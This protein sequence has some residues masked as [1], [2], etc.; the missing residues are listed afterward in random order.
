MN[1]VLLTLTVLILSLANL[2]G[3][4]PDG[5]LRIEML[6][7]FNLVVDHN[8]QTPSGASPRAVYLGVRFCNDG[9]NELTDV[10][11]YIGNQTAGTP[12]VYPVTSVSSGPYTGSFSFTHE[13][14]V[15]DATR[16]IGTLA[17]GEC[18]TQYWL[19]SYPLLDANGNRVTGS[20]PDQTDDLHLSYDVWAS[21]N[22]AGTS[23]NA[24]TS[25]TVQLRAMISASANKIWP[26]TTSK[27]PD[28]FLAAFPDKQLGWRQTTATP[29]PGASVV[30][31]GIWFDLGNIRKGFDNNGDFVPDF[32][33]MLQP[34]GNPALYDASCFRLVKVSGMIAVKLHGNQTMSFEFEDQMHFSGI[35]EDNTGAVGMVF[36]EFAV[37]NGPCAS[38]LT[39]YQE[40]ASGSNNEK[41][42]GDYGVPGG[43][44]VSAAPVVSLVK[45]A[46]PT[47]GRG[48][49]I[50]L[51]YTLTNS[52]AEPIGLTAYQT[53]LV[54]QNKIPASTTYVSGSAAAENILPAGTQVAILFSTDNG[55]SWTETEPSPASSVTDIQW[56]LDQ[57]LNPGQTTS[58]TYDILI[59][60]GYGSPV[61]EARGGASLGNSEPFVQY[62]SQTVIDG[63]FSVSGKVF[64]DNG[65]GGGTIGD[66]VQNGSETGIPN[67]GVKLY[68]DSNENGVY[69]DG[70]ILT[71]EKN[72]NASGNYDFTNLSNGK[73]VVKIYKNDPGLPAQWT[74][75]TPLFYSI[76]DLANITETPVFGYA[77]LLTVENSLDGQSPVFESDIVAYEL[78]L[79]NKSHPSV[80]SACNEE[81][82]AWASVVDGETNYNVSPQN[83]LGAPDFN[84][85]HFTGN[86]SK[87]AV[88]KGFNF[89]DT[90][91]EIQ[92]VE[93]LIQFYID[94]DI[95]NDKLYASIELENGQT[96]TVPNP[97]WTKNSSPS[98]NDYEGVSD[99]GMITVDIT[100][101]QDWDWSIFDADWTVKLIS[102]VKG[103]NDGAILWLDAIGVKI[104]KECPSG[105]GETGEAEPGDQY[106][107]IDELP[108][109]YNFDPG[110]LKFISATVSPDSISSG[111]LFW[112]NAGP[113]YPA[114][115]E[116]IGLNFRALAPD[117]SAC[118]VSAPECTSVPNPYSQCS[119]PTSGYYQDKTINGNVTW[120]SIFNENANNVT[121]MIRVK[122]HGSITVPSG[123]LKIGATLLVVDGVDLIVENGDL[124]M[125]AWACAIFVNSTV[126]VK[127]SLT[128]TTNGF[129]CMTDCTVEIGDELAN[130]I[131]NGT[132]SSTLGHFTNN[133]GTRYLENVCLNVTGDYI[134]N[135]G[136]NGEDVFINVCGHI[137]DRG[138][139][140]A[141]TGVL[142]GLD[143]GSFKVSK[144]ARMYN[145]EFIVANDVQILSG[146]TLQACNI[147]FRT[148]N[149]NFQNSGIFKGCEN[150]IWVSDGRSISNSSSWTANVETRRGTS[151]LGSQYLPVNSSVAQISP[152][153]NDCACSVVGS[154]GNYI[155]T[156]LVV[157]GAKNVSNSPVNEANDIEQI[158][159]LP[160]GS[161]Y[162][163]IF[164]DVDKDGWKGTYGF[165]SGTDYFLEGVE[166]KIY[167]CTNDWGDL[168]YPAPKSNKSCTHSQNGGQWNLIQTDTTGQDGFYS[169]NGLRNGYYYVQVTNA[170][171][172]GELD[173]TADP[174]IT[175][176]DC[177][178]SGDDRWKNPSSN[179]SNMGIIGSVNDHTHINFG[180]EL[181]EAVSGI[182]WEDLDGDGIQEPGEDP[183]QGV[184]VKLIHSGCSNCPSTTTNAGGE[185]Q[186][187]G[188]TPGVNYTLQVLTGSVPGGGTWTVTSESDGTADN[189]IS[190][191]LVSGEQRRRNNFG[192]QPSGNSD[193]GGV[194]YYDWHGNAFRNECDEGIAG[195]TLKLYQDENGDGVL[196]PEDGLIQ[197]RVTNLI[198]QYQFPSKGPGNYI[199]KINE[200]T[201]PI[202]PAQTKDYNEN[203]ICTVCD[204][205]A[206]ILGI[207][208]SNDIADIDFG[209]K[210]TGTGIVR[211]VLFFDSN[212]NGLR[213]NNEQGIGEIEVRLEADLNNNGDFRLIRTIV[214][215]SDGAFRFT[216]LP[217]GPYR[218][219]AN[220]LDENLPADQYGAAEILTTA[221]S[222]LTQVTDASMVSVNGTDCGA[223][224]VETVAFG[225]SNAGSLESFVFFDANANGTMDW[226]ENGIPNIT[227]YLCDD[228]DGTCGAT[229]ALDTVVT[230]ATGLYLFPGLAASDYVVAVDLN[231][232]PSGMVLTADPTAD[233]IPCY[234]PLDMAD[235][236]YNLLNLEC[237]NAYKALRINLG[238]QSRNSNFGYQPGG[239]IGC[240][241]WRDINVNGLKEDNEP[242]LPNIRMRVT[243]EDPA[244]INGIDYPPGTYTDTTYTDFDGN[245][246]FENL[247]DGEWRVEVDN[248]ADMAATY[249]PDGVPDNVTIVTIAGGDVT[250]TGNTWCP[251]GEDCA[252]KVTF[253]LRPNYPNSISGTVCLDSDQDGKCSTG[254]EAFPNGVTIYLADEFGNFW[255]ETRIDD[256]GHYSFEYLPASTF[257]VSI[258][259]E[260]TPLQLAS[261]TTSLGDTPAFLISETNSN[262]FQKVNVTAAL[263]GMDFGFAFTD[264][265]DLGDLPLP[266]QST[267]DG[268]YAGPAHLLPD[269]PNLYL[270][271]M[272]DAETSP[273]LNA[274]ASGDDDNGNDDDGITFSDPGGWTAGP[275]STG[276]GGSLTA[277]VT[278]AGWL[279]AWLDFNRDGDFTDAG[280]MAISQ[281]VTTGLYDIDFDIPAG[282]VLSGGQDIYVRVRLFSS[283]PFAPQ[284]AYDGIADNGEVEDYLVSVCHNL[285]F[286][287]TITGAET[288]C[289]NC[290]PSMITVV[291][292]PSGGGG[293]IFY[294]WQQS[295]NGGVTWEDIAGATVDT[296]TPGSLSQT[297]LFRRG[298]KRSRCGNY[299]YS[300]AVAKTVVTNFTD[301][302]IIVG[303][304]D[305][306]GIY[307]PDIIVSVISPSGGVGN[308]LLLYQWQQSM[309]DGATWLDI[310]NAND[311][312]FNPGIISQTTKYR[313]SSQKAPCMTF[314]YSNVITKM[315]AVNFVSG[316]TIAGDETFCGSYDPG[317]IASVSDA[318]GGADGY[319]MYQWEYSTN[320]GV[321]WTTISG[322]TGL[323]YNPGTISQTTNY[324]RKARR[325]PCSVWVNSN[326]V[327]K[328]VRQYPVAVITT[329]PSSLSGYLCEL[330]DYEFDAADAGAGAT[331]GWDFG[332]YANPASKS[333]KGSHFVEFDVP[334]DEA[335]STT[336]VTLTI[337]KNG[338][339]ATDS[340][341][342]NLRPEIQITGIILDDP[343][344]CKTKNGSIT[345]NATS[346]AGTSIEYTVDG[347]LNWDSDNSITQLGAGVYEVMVRYTGSDCPET[348]GIVALSDPPPAAD[349][350]ISTT[351]TCT[352][353][354]VTVE[355]VATNG[356]PTFSW[357]FGNNASPATASGAGPHNVTFANGGAASIAV[358]MEDGDCIG[359]RDTTIAIVQ[360]Y[361]SG[362]AILGGETLC[363]TFDPSEI[364]AS[365]NPSGGTGGTTVYQWEKRNSNGSGGWTAWTEIAGANTPGYDPPI[366]SVS[367]QYRRKVRRAPCSD[368][369]YSNEVAAVL[370]KKP[371]LADD[372]YAT[373][374]PGFPY[375]G[376]VSDNDLNLVSPSFN[377]LTFPVNGSLDFDA[378]GEFIYDP[379]ATFCGSESFTYVVCN[380]GSTCCDTA[381]VV[382][383]M[384]DNTAPSIVN[385]PADITISCDDQIPLAE[386]VQVVENCQMISLGLN[387]FITKGP[388]M[389]CAPY[390]YQWVRIWNSVD[391]C[392]NT[393]S[394]QQVIHVQDN[395]SPDIYR[396]YTLPNGKR[397][398]AGVMENVSKY[399]KTVSLPV[400]FATQPVVFTQVTSRDEASAVVVRLRN[401]STTQFQI[402]LQ[403]EEGNDGNHLVEK[404]AWVAMEKGAQS[405]SLPFEVNT[406]L[407]GSNPANKALG[408]TY[409]S[410]PDF[411]ASMQ[412]NNDSD[413][414]NVRIANLTQNS[415]DIWVSEENSYDSE[416]T[417]N[418]ET[419]GYLAIYS[420]GDIK[421]NSGEVIGEVGRVNLTH[422]IQVVSLNNEYH[423][424][425]VITG[426]V[427]NNET[428][429]VTARVMNV[430]STS[431]ELKLDE[432]DYLDGT[433][434]TENV[435]YMVIE[436]SLPLDRSVDCDNIPAALKIGTE[437]VA[438]DN[439]DAHIDFSMTES[440]VD[441]N[442]QSDTIFTRTWHTF[443]DCGNVTELVQTYR[444]IDTIPP[445]FTVPADVT[446]V[447]SDSKDNLAKTGDVTDESDNCALGVNAVYTDNLSN[448]TGCTG[449]ILRTWTAQDDCGNAT[450]KI[451]TISIAPE[452]DTD[453]DGVVDYF[454]LDD[455]NDG[456]PDEIETENDFDLDGIP[457]SKDLDSDND[458]IPDLIEAGGIDAN[459]DGVIDFVGTLGWDHDGDGLA[460]GFDGNDI[461]KS[462]AA[463]NTFNPNSPTN[464]RDGDG[465]PNFLDRDSDNDGIPDLIE[466]GGL[467][468]NGD[469]IVDYPVL[470]DP[471]TMIDADG[472]GFD[473]RYDPDDDNVPGAE[474][475]HDPLIVFNGSKYAGGL[476]TDKPDTDSDLVPDFLDSDSDNDGISDLIEAGG[477][478][479]DGD[480]KLELNASFIDLNNDGF[481]DI[482]VTYPLIKTDG[483]GFIINGRPE[484]TNSDGTAFIGGDADFDGKPN[485]RDTDSDNDGI[486]DTYE[487]GIASRDVNADGVIDNFIDL[488]LNGFDDTAQASANI[489]TESDGFT[490]DGRPEDSSDADGTAYLGA[491][492]DGAFAST[493]GNPDIDD[494]GDGILNFLDTDSDNDFLS[495]KIEDANGN[496]IFDLGETGLFNPDTDGDDII[497]GVED[498]NHNGKLDTGETDPLNPD[499]D[500]DQLLD[501]EEDLN[502]D[503][504]AGPGESDPIDPCDPF[505]SLACR[506]VVLNV[507]VKLLGPL[508]GNDSTNYM[509]DE[510]RYKFV[511]PTLEPYTSM[512]NLQ[513]VGENGSAGNP[514][515]Q[516]GQSNNGKE[517]IQPGLLY[518]TGLDAPVDWV[519]IELRAASKP[520]SIV[521]SRAAVLQADGD[522][523]DVDG[524]SYVKF[525]EFPSGE[526]F[527]AIRHRN[528]LGVMTDQPY[529]LSPSPTSIDF[530]D[531]GLE[532][533]G[534]ENA[535]RFVNGEMTLW[536]GDLN[537]DGKVVYQ[538]PGNDVLVLFQQVLVNDFNNSELA[539][540]VLEGYRTSDLNLDG[541]SIFQGPNNDK[542][543]LLINT[544]FSSPDNLALWANFVLFEKLP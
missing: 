17:P 92:K 209:Y 196:Q 10:F 513:H 365:S 77:P 70:D 411:F 114:Q 176:G 161:V 193:L 382:I 80:T 4:N 36:Y 389:M 536:P 98:L 8:I 537:N 482:Y 14:G 337:T 210:V 475:P 198:G 251:S 94:E 347:G 529:L 140:D 297:T 200:N 49:Q 517:K 280:E 183:L 270:G 474:D 233:G 147:D 300:N 388:D 30:L 372:N 93:L 468:T 62:L 334:D 240:M 332:A 306:C 544:T 314:V 45:I 349:I 459:G 85:A 50:E 443:D 387:E 279:I 61:L 54:F 496:G 442:C 53:P 403:E 234:T 260:Q 313:R 181:D 287:G 352:G 12:G 189:A 455:D 1:K 266:Y 175:N 530:S 112:E 33:F 450:T 499:T 74:N 483:D 342:L 304:Q 319:Q 23:R 272:V 267:V 488:D 424:P 433:H 397:M 472:D 323:T 386:A 63:N 524:I 339:F 519:L 173:Q 137:G 358:T 276:N 541:S 38:Q 453:H 514:P 402:R 135:S 432:F 120:S 76:E 207:N 180:Y 146:G 11:A 217:D 508:V 283:R 216:G 110:K 244:N 329:S 211:G 345:I 412:T 487:T 512:P 457:N 378:D 194:V 494:D 429:P 458:G 153:F 64:Q 273:D 26:N 155:T 150:T 84:M 231:T 25:K 335:S 232:L 259:K 490:I 507:R 518:V 169:F 320:G 219:S 395:T 384:T 303:D 111:A 441:F 338:C 252:M 178:N 410:Q 75:T 477:V 201:L 51:G 223:C 430:T 282:T 117:P 141:S 336:T 82:Y 31:E 416:T 148:L 291:N 214:S 368:W 359:V 473:D 294:Q 256:F 5:D 380:D 469:G 409:P 222:F 437:I 122:G 261:M 22:D 171:I 191:N 88:V 346:P 3:A 277:E 139:S 90:S 152:F 124:V 527:V 37:L 115:T 528:H 281:A 290:H 374:C 67:I 237:D 121:K 367:T 515:G 204:A 99:Q 305:N 376:N 186:F 390:H 138:A 301:P 253:G 134:L 192:I 40:V 127:G 385:V 249:D 274:D 133:S 208:G 66:G 420:P 464:D 516:G 57:P 221:G 454:D 215:D 361:S 400:Q 113:L 293:G 495:D 540:F 109:R 504:V 174:D 398:V 271:Q 465:I 188:L 158:E 167:G 421:T 418:L 375:A 2:F 246:T 56:W 393:A 55:G 71:Q 439:C 427:T 404:V 440:Q 460:Y 479:T 467:D 360:N 229:N 197:T 484:D 331:Y 105:G 434:A 227:L 480:G 241:V 239:V 247:P 292:P 539:N 371:N 264:T 205:K 461:D 164:G 498:R 391:Y 502:F 491:L 275:S 159:I 543:L 476:I 128:E 202:Y 394:A 177:G 220:P 125:D 295:A 466:A 521:A 446:I 136:S 289:N 250:E 230:D 531:P 59:D 355:A 203:G 534:G 149:G 21:A 47:A 485:F 258:S 27:V 493:N 407:L 156:E 462:A 316:G 401:V 340:K 185:Y 471:L 91:G 284:T 451:Q 73:Y 406:W 248:P 130:G 363:S 470:S 348:Y 321:N 341:V 327:T 449:Y 100:N 69:D 489:S 245:Y 423:N 9:G 497:D 308:S 254:G 307:D 325:T 190:C 52:T 333:G 218:V 286:A 353:Q 481:H 235:P 48:T 405:G 68:F 58:V 103:G 302:G 463:S 501:G 255:G 16:Y 206:K 165:E 520:D 324:R 28:E 102:A 126:Q 116:T 351:E 6:E 428:D 225:F 78:K 364:V 326:V 41:H 87:K 228:A 179:M 500:G 448:L 538:G 172:L 381:A 65:T 199:V 182:V 60:P 296:F 118:D 356:D 532:V 435:A 478:D 212:A 422:S 89:S 311:E 86:W 328:E 83:M 535:R 315:V 322:A 18:V 29:Y 343:T 170:S 344:Q 506:G 503:G 444:L 101:L 298:A 145:C 370:V 106:S 257:T 166:V 262:A 330:T 154:T 408:Q 505:L 399:W 299:I 142:D 168:L 160:R 72:T 414:A 318:S 445:T 510:L 243:N 426:A 379:N 377:I 522:V 350:L 526:Y 431:F 263:T 265:F 309:D 269:V 312:F 452:N 187:S 242:G 13:G 447:C 415:T 417:H 42:N 317:I 357:F 35:P 288:G 511:L 20:K 213:N 108:V 436:G 509:R 39:P 46:P 97:A 542:A 456:I 362:G 43:A 81:V 285:T 238:T 438:V 268:A 226:N 32:N 533:Y 354:V 143:G 162:G 525:H 104:T 392:T 396:I 425:V 24:N 131:F 107:V 523:R 366:I 383:N 132:G 224:P 7:Y 119:Q 144:L 373:V 278:G 184:T 129:L 15:K 44:L 123:N 151:S 34:V 369:V 310:V 95:N 413:P 79:S 157:S 492:P 163:Y 19:V 486:K 236:Y 195:V 419:V 96:A